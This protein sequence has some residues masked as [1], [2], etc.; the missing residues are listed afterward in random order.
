M[1]IRA[2]LLIMIGAII[3]PISLFAAVALQTLL[4]SEREHAL[5][6]LEDTVSATVL[7]VD[8]ELSSA[9]A[10]LR[11]LAHSPHLAHGD[12]QAFYEHAQSADRGE[13]GRTILFDPAGQ[14]IINTVI[15]LGDP[16]PPPPDYVRVR[17]RQVIDTQRTV[18]SGLITG[19]VQRVP[20]TTINVPVPL[21]EGRRYVLASVFGTDYFN[22]LIAQRRVPPSWALA[23]VDREGRFIARSRETNRIGQVANPELLRVAAG[24]TRGLLRTKTIAGVD[25]YFAFT[26]SPMSGWLVAVS[27]PAAEIEGAARRAVTLAAIGM[28]VAVLCAAGAAVFFARRLVAS[29]RGAASAATTLGHGGVPAAAPA[30]IAEVKELHRS[31]DEAAHKLA[32]AQAERTSLLEREQEAR[33]VA[34]QQVQ[35]RDEFLAML[36]HELRNPL[37]GIV[38]AAQLLRMDAA[39]PALKEHAQD[40]LLRQ[41]KHLT[42]IVDDLLD[43]AR[44]ARGKVQLDLRPVDLAA[45]IEST[46][47]ALRIAGKV[48]HRLGCRLEPAWVLADRTRIEQ[49]VGNLVTNALKY[50]PKG[51]TIDITLTNGGGEACLAVRDSGVGIAPELMPQLFD[52][53]VQGKVSLDRAQG[54]L[55]IGLSLVRSLVALHGGSISA[56]SAGTGQG[57]TFILRLPLLDEGDGDTPGATAKPT[58]D[59]S[60]GAPI[61][62]IEDNQ[63]ARQMLAAQLATMGY[64]VLEA[65]NGLDGLALA[66]R[67][68][69]GL[70]IVDIGLPGMNGY[71]IAAQMR[72]DP[73]LEQVRLVALTGY[74]QEADRRRALDA[75]FDAHLVKPLKFEDL[76]ALL[77]V[78]A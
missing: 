16:L 72:R 66:R 12:M 47:D 48:E 15:P 52:I 22:E 42:R 58:Q 39:N 61:L 13:T 2:Y 31:I 43:L 1:K 19:A 54:G 20:V 77:D 9:E 53:F 36:S 56:E 73:A 14:Q 64:R 6:A 65:D 69:P 38:G 46:V 25:A 23:V 8:R 35:I 18:V 57:S 76:A 50:T 3:L 44:L 67:E 51:G 32:E 71:E 78:A 17:T 63:D 4:R 60:L 27:A 10:A 68:R 40:I 7:L 30:S 24:K 49:V 75:G 28:L 34:E 70:A 62:L 29:I 5:Q 33:V 55:G 41:G 45:V 21:G 74:G 26:R 37:S 11:V 59:A